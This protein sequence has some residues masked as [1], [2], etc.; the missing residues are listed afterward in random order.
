[1]QHNVSLVNEVLERPTSRPYFVYYHSGNT[2][3]IT[4]RAVHY[5]VTLGSI[6]R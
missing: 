6:S 3:H 1:M 5:R 4:Q 2:I